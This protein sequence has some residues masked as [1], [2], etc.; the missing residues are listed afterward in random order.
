MPVLSTSAIV[1][2]RLRRMPAQT[3]VNTKLARMRSSLL[4]R[5]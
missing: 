1:M 3:P 5:Y 4:A 2:V